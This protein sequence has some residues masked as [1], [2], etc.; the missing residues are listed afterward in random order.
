[1]ASG[2]YHTSTVVE[3]SAG[4]PSTG[5]YCEKP[6]S[7]AARRLVECAVDAR[8]GLEPRDRDGQLLLQAV[9]GGRIGSARLEHEQQGEHAAK[10]NCGLRIVDCGLASRADDS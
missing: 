5:R 2:A 10:I 8:V 7:R 1:M 3:S 6:T 4:R 9:V